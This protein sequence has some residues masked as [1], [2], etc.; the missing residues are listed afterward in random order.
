MM[1]V[2]PAAA[3]RAFGPGSMAALAGAAFLVT[4]LAT[5]A[6][7]LAAPA[8]DSGVE[9]ELASL[10]AQTQAQKQEIDTQQNELEQLRMELQ[11]QQD[12]L[13]RAGLLDTAAQTP[14][15]GPI[16]DV[17]LVA[18]A[19][20]AA[21]GSSSSSAAGG[22]SAERPKSERQADQ[23]LVDAGGVL[24]PRWTLQVE[25]SM[26]DTHVSNPRVN[27]FGYTVF[28]AINIGLIRVD[29]LSQDALN[30]NV[31][32]R[33]GMPHRTQVDVR[34][35]WTFSFVRQT[36]GIGTGNIS[37]VNTQGS[38]IGDISTTFYWQP[39]VANGWRPAV[40]LRTQL[41]IPTGE[42]VFA[43]PEAIPPNGQGAET[44]L[45]RAPT[46]SGYFSVTPGF[47]LVWRSDPLVLFAGGSYGM[48]LASRHY[49]TT[50]FNPNPGHDLNGNPLPMI[51][52]R[53]NGIIQAGSVYN[54]N[55]G[56]NFAVNERASINFSFNDFF[57]GYTRQRA[58]YASPF[59]KVLGTTIND[60]R[61]GMGASFGLTNNVA[62]VVNAGMGLTDQSPAYTFAV[63][64][65]ITLP[66]RK[67]P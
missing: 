9:S 39:F 55:L 51:T 15:S 34:V 7:A 30:T 10:R 63:S 31:T 52:P 60:A 22:V 40:V 41:I 45:T 37:E 25:P 23:L 61:F 18:N 28:N 6:V 24:L 3:K 67:S 19:P 36:K 42:S 8:A 59:S 47:T 53:N 11:A 21:Q 27:I 29:D 33:L 66:L 2:R 62:L 50:L 49:V 44:Q 4:A 1:D 35:P 57:T 43:I 20:G 38:H 32:F 54:A 58:N 5:P 48:P 46:G 17:E 26:D 64:L 14:R 13:R 65:P 56:V 12:I 16:P